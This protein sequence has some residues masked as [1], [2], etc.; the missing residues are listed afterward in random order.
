M[1]NNPTNTNTDWSKDH[2]IKDQR[3]SIEA[4]EEVC[5]RYVREIHQLKEELKK[6]EKNNKIL[7]KEIH[8]N[9]VNHYN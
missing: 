3:T 6:S 9:I 2:I 4:L 7:N 5:M 1:E 8:D